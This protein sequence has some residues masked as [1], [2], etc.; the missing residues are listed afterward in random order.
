MLAVTKFLPRKRMNPMNNHSNIQSGF[1]YAMTELIIA[2][3][4]FSFSIKSSC[5]KPNGIR[6]YICHEETETSVNVYVVRAGKELECGSA[7]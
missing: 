3:K 4:L 6:M 7:A 1:A 2:T 5:S